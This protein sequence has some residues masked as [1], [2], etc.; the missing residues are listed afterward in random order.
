MP[1]AQFAEPWDK[2]NGSRV[3]MAW[4]RGNRYDRSG[5]LADRA[6]SRARHALLVSHRVSGFVPRVA[7]V[8]LS[9]LC[10]GLTE[11][12]SSLDPHW[13]ASRFLFE[14]LALGGCRLFVSEVLRGRGWM[15]SIQGDQRKN[16]DGFRCWWKPARRRAERGH[17]ISFCLRTRLARK[18]KWRM[19]TDPEGGTWS[20]KRR[21]NSTASR[22]MVL[23]RE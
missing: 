7:V 9:L 14:A 15:G 13:R 4:R 23:V 21:M 20:R 1:C 6:L 22:V 2:R 16:R 18:P 19:R 3:V 5:G 10:A 11:A 8:A 12:F 17:R